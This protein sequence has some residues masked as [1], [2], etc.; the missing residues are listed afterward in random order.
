[1]ALMFNLSINVMKVNKA[2]LVPGKNGAQFLNL[3]VAVNDDPDQDGNDVSC[4]EGQNKEYR[5]AKMRKNYLGNGRV[6]WR[7]AGEKVQQQFSPNDD[8]IVI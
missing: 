1:M 5:Q 8:E 7:D 3:T 4:W 2:K 6:F